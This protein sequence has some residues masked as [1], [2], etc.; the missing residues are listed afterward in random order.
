MWLVFGDTSPPANTHLAKSLRLPDR[1][2]FR[3]RSDERVKIST[4]TELERRNAREAEEERFDLET[5]SR[6]RGKLREKE[7]Y[8]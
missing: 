2:F 6:G 5:V 8:G 7:H 1:V 3:K 4:S